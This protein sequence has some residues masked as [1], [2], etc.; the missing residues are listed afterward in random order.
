ML[1]DDLL[2]QHSIP[3]L[4]L[5]QDRLHKEA[6]GKKHELQSMVGSKYHD[7][8]QS[9]DAITIMREKSELMGEK[10]ASFFSSSQ[11]LVLATNELLG[12]DSG[13]SKGKS[14]GG[15]GSSKSKFNSI[16]NLTDSSLWALLERCDVFNASLT[17]QLARLLLRLDS[18]AY[19]TKIA[20]YSLPASLESSCRSIVFL[21]QTVTEDARLVLLLPGLS[22]ADKAQT[23]ASLGLLSGLQRGDLLQRFLQGATLLLGEEEDVAEDAEDD[24]EHDGEDDDDARLS[25]GGKFASHLFHLFLPFPS[26]G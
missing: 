2:K 1:A 19:I 26:L 3:E 17:V 22:G 5:L 8:I 16:I 15:A 24:G 25:A 12:S 20:S 18:P 7:F 13:S 9:A 10:L 21:Q 11:D 14:S 6:N 23:L 4:R